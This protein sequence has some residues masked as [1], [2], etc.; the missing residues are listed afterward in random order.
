MVDPGIVT[1]ILLG[2]DAF[3]RGG[4]RPRG[5]G[6][7]LGDVVGVPLVAGSFASQNSLPPKPYVRHPGGDR[8]APAR[9]IVESRTA[10]REAELATFSSSIGLR[11]NQT[12]N[13]PWYCISLR[14]NWAFTT[15]RP[16]WV[17]KRTSVKY[18]CFWMQIGS[19]SFGEAEQKARTRA[20]LALRHTGL[21]EVL[22]L[23]LKAAEALEAV[24]IVLVLAARRRGIVVLALVARAAHQRDAGDADHVVSVEGVGQSG[25]HGV[26][27]GQGAFPAHGAFVRGDVCPRPLPPLRT[28]VARPSAAAHSGDAETADAGDADTAARPSPG[29]PGVPRRL[30]DSRRH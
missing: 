28:A 11:K 3:R 17:V 1:G 23:D 18:S 14:R 24:H 20:D 30:A 2:L 29:P 4:F 27:N 26:L 5:F 25:L 12:A 22:A 9:I 16:I 13:S 7:E 21:D 6:Q 10:A 15:K 8:P 19:S